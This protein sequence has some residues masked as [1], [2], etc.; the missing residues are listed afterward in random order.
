MR[1]GSLRHLVEGGP[2]SPVT[3]KPP[4]ATM[5]GQPLSRTAVLMRRLGGKA[6]DSQ[7][8]KA[9][10]RFK[11]AIR[12]VLTSVKAKTWALSAKGTVASKTRQTLGRRGSIPI[13]GLLKRGGATEHS[14]ASL[15]RCMLSC[16]L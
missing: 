2:R 16:E 7:S 13:S 14:P 15:V 5:A 8:D 3:K 1:K 6:R 10:A 12:A 4:V 9:S 11:A